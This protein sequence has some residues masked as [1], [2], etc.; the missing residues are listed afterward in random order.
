MTT[1]HSHPFARL[2]AVQAKLVVREPLVLAF[3]FAFPVICTLILSG[4]F[5]PDDNSFGALPSD[6]YAVAYIA[7]AIGAIG[8]TTVPVQVA[9]ARERGVLRRF[10]ASGMPSWY[11]PATMVIVGAAMA[12]IAAGLVVLTSALA[13][14]LVAP[15]DW[16]RTMGSFVLAV[17]AFVSLGVL[18][19]WIMPNARAAQG[20]GTLAFFPM[21]L[22]GGGGPPP[23]ALSSVMNT[24]ATWLPLTHVMRAVQEPW[25]ALEGNTDHLVVLAAVGLASTA[26]WWW[27][28]EKD[29]VA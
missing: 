6:Y 21:F 23:D 22:L 25:L 28:A 13:Y 27:L 16:A 7:V 8:L 2:V 9:S 19:G 20:I 3:V 26:S 1:T 5:D 11:F 24:I 4:V 10:R 14:G 18:L 29:V 17:L 12:V 15:D